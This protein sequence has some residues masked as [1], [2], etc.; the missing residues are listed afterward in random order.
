MFVTFADPSAAE[1]LL[2]I[3][4]ERRKAPDFFLRNTLSH[5]VV[6]LNTML[7]PTIMVEQEYEHL[8]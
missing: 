1:R 2:Q 7:V 6:G 5:A 8:V 3:A 4:E